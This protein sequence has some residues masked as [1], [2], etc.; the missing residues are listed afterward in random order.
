MDDQDTSTGVV[1]IHAANSAA[2]NI[3][4]LLEEPM[5][6]DVE[7][8]PKCKVKCNGK[9][10]TSLGLRCIHCRKRL[11]ASS[12]IHLCHCRSLSDTCGPA[13]RN[14]ARLGVIEFPGL[15]ECHILRG[16]WQEALQLLGL[17]YR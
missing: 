7:G 16:Q 3:A 17:L 15:A 1:S 9:V 13:Q 8:G 10:I 2:I 14:I 5:W 11:F 6:D 12:Y 4:S